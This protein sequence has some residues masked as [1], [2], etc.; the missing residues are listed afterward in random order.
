MGEEKAEAIKTHVKVD[1][2]VKD[3]EDLAKTD[4]KTQV[5][6]AAVFGQHLLLG[7]EP[8]MAACCCYV[9]WAVWGCLKQPACAETSLAC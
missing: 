5:S 9:T 1:L 8:L 2:D 3:Q 4:A 7:S 6:S